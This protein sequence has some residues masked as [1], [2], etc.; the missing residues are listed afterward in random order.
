MRL[1]RLTYKHTENEVYVN[2]DII[3]VVEA[4]IGYGYTTILTTI[5]VKLLV[6]ETPYD[7]QQLCL[8]H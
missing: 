8:R 3:S 4:A 2:V 7:I 6:T 5:N 1:I